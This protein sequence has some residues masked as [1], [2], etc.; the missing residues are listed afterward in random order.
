MSCF[1]NASFVVLINS[2]T[3][4]FFQSEHGLQQGCLLSPL[5][6][7]LIMESI[8]LLLRKN[9]SEGGLSGIKVSRVIK[10]LHLIFFDDILIMSKASLEE[11]M[12]IKLLME[13]FCCASGLKVNFEK[14][15]FH[16]SGLHGG[17][18][19]EDLER[20]KEAFAINFVAL[21]EGFRYLG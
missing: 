17:L 3:S 15:T 19:G 4:S 5:L 21:S 2:E 11:W 18:H 6:F 14:S 10:I 13:L 1:V 20:L 7:I 9:L 8:S 16:H 12:L